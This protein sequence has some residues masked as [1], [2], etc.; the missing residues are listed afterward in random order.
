MQFKKSLM[1]ATMLTL[2]GF[3]AMSANAESPTTDTFDVTMTVASNCTVVAGDT[4]S[5]G[6][7][8]AG[9]T[10]AIGMSTLNVACSTG[11]PYTIS[12][13]PSATNSAGLGTMKGTL[14][15]ED[16]IEYQMTSDSAGETPWT[17]DSQGGTGAGMGTNIPHEVYA[18]V[19]ATNLAIVKPDVYTETVTVSVAY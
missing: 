7:V 6:T 15:N 18:K 3:A 12:M 10:P 11:T 2:G 5:L 8:D 14:L 17:D 1:T 4:I 16:T 9:V 13:L 19:T